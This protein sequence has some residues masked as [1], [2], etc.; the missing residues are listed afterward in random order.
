[1]TPSPRTVT[2]LPG[3]GIGPE[4]TASVTSIL[5]AAGANLTWERHAAGEESIKLSGMPL[6]PA[7]LASIQRT[8]VCLKGPVG[9]PIGKGFKSV[10]VTLRQTLDLYA[11]LRPVKNVP[12]VPARY[13]DLDLIV[14]RENTESL[15]SGI[16]HVVVPGV[17][18]SIKI[19]TE[20]ASTRIARFAFEFARAH[21][22]RKV[23]IVHKANIMKLS[24]GLFLD[25]CRTVAAG[26][27]DVEVNDVIVDAA[28]MKLVMNPKQFD[29][30]LLDNL[31]GD[32]ISDLASGLVGGLGVTP[33]ANLGETCA[34]FESVHGSAPDIAGKGIANPTALL[35][36]AVM[37]LRHLEDEASAARVE[38]ALFAALE[39]GTARTRDVGGTATTDTFTRSVVSRL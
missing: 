24:D 36:S 27:P 22:R 3:D 26:Y 25:S 20:K 37:M 39:E 21:G 6:P 13:G 4:I 14:V 35:L 17:V 28:C 1:M 9:T 29:I 31:Y 32:I 5:D 19:I 16:E 12:G 30:L 23:T 15:Y 2:L 18:E 7:T 38:K 11:N 34:V 33:G 10:N 8:R